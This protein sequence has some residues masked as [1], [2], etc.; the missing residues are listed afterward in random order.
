MKQIQKP[1]K[2]E[3]IRELPPVSKYRVR[4]LLN[5]KTQARVLDIREF[6][7]SES[8]EGFTR[9]GIRIANRAEV[10]ALRDCLEE[11]LD[12]LKA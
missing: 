5:P 6:V 7:S 4:V 3:V 1:V 11:V 2:E 9:R 12:I 8:F 10:D